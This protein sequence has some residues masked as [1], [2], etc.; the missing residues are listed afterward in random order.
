MGRTSGCSPVGSRLRLNQSA[1]SDGTV[2]TPGSTSSSGLPLPRKNQ[3]GVY[4][5]PSASQLHE[6]RR[7]STVIGIRGK[8]ANPT[9]GGSAASDRK[10]VGSGGQSKSSAVIHGSPARSELATQPLGSS[11]ESSGTTSYQA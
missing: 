2:V 6:R 9:P 5:D 1:T 11:S 7:A 8:Q 10:S 4:Q 3:C